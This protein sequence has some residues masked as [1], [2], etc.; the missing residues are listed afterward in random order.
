MFRQI[1]ICVFCAS[2]FACS[3]PYQESGLLGGVHATQIDADTIQIVGKGN[4][5]TSASTIQNYVLLKA[6]DETL[7][8]GYDLFVVVDAADETRH[9][10]IYVPGQTTSNTTGRAT[11]WGNTIQGTSTTQT[12]TTP[13]TTFGIVKPGEAVTIKMFKGEKPANGPPNLY[14]A[15]EIETYLGPQ[16]RGRS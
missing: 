15:K 9:G 12:Y 4:G 1:A 14:S 11:V 13:G 8:H 7:A 10:T 3:T 5:F 2:L 6:A 16:V